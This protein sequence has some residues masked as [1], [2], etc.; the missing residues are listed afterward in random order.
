MDYGAAKKAFAISCLTAVFFTSLV[1]GASAYDHKDKKT[2][3]ETKG[4]DN[5]KRFYLKIESGLGIQDNKASAHISDQDIISFDRK[6]LGSKTS[7]DPYYNLA[8]GWYLPNRRHIRTEISIGHTGNKWKNHNAFGDLYGKT[9]IKLEESYAMASLFYIFESRCLFNA[10]PFVFGGVGLSSAHCKFKTHGN[11]TILS[12]NAIKATLDNA[13]RERKKG[14]GVVVGINGGLED[15]IIIPEMVRYNERDGGKVEESQS[16]SLKMTH[17]DRPVFKIGAGLSFPVSR[18]V[19]IDLSYGLS[20][21]GQVRIDRYSAF[22][23]KNGDNMIGVSSIRLKS[24]IR[25]E[26]GLGL[27]VSF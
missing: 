12:G 1:D 15:P 18:A 25:Q 22:M 26:V 10:H 16:K 5:H 27:R 9:N 21:L 6:N 17:N 14:G 13:I 7:I 20:N 2:N 19:D 3:K 4:D 24:K 23:I 8:F 11:T